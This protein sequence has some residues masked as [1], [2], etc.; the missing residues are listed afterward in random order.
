MIAGSE[1]VH[2]SVAILN[3]FGR[4]LGDGI[5]G[6]QALQVA[7]RVGAVPPY[8]TLFRLP[9][10]PTMVQAI[11]AAA[12]FAA[13]RALPRGFATRDRRFEVEGFDRVIDLRDF[14]FDPDFRCRPMIDFF[15]RRLGVEPS[16]VP[17]AARR[18]SWVAE[19]VKPEKP[20]LP[21]GYVLVCPLASMALR[22]MPEEVHAHILRWTQA[23][24]PTVTQ[25]EVPAGLE[26]LVLRAP[27]CASL[28]TLSGLVRHA[29]RVIST[30]TAMVHLADAFEVPCLAFFPT[31]RPEWRVRDY[32]RCVPVPLRSR[33]PLGTEFARGPADNSR[34][35]SAWFP[36]GDDLTWLDRVLSRDAS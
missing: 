13:I 6:L 5:I 29:R 36:E 25:G 7:I 18:N 8:P 20:C 28:E 27:A 1:S 21:D 11:H 31:H 3:G 4:T 24:A 19:H 34:A 32:P 2:S 15:L 33:L 22:T 14:A 26:G 23:I 35:R 9:D 16:Q 12:G 30:D 17:P 10:L